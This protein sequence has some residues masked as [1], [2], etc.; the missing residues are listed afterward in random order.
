MDF[1][2]PE[3]RLTAGEKLQVFLLSLTIIPFILVIF[4]G[5]GSQ[6]PALVALVTGLA[7]VAAAYF[8]S[9]ATESLE[10]VVSQ[11]LALAVLALI[12]VLPEYSFEVVLVWGGHLE[13][14]AATMTGAN[15]LLLGLGW[16]AIFFL[17]Y[18]GS[19]RRHQALT[20]VE[21]DRHQ[22][23]EIVFLLLASLYSLVIVAK[24]SLTALDA[25]VLVAIYVAYVFAAIRLPRREENRER[26]A[27][28]A[29]KIAL[30][31]GPRKVA[32]V[33]TL[34][35]FGAFVIFFGAEPF[36]DSLL[37]VAV[38]L[39]LSEYLFVQ[40][41]APFLSEFPESLTAFIWAYSVAKAPMGLANLVSSKL[42]QWTLLMATIPLVYSLSVGHLATLKLNSLQVEE[43]MLTAAQTFFGIAALL[44]LRFGWRQATILFGLFLVQFVYPPTHVPVTIIFVVLAVIEVFVK[45]HN[46]VLFR[47]FSQAL[48]PLYS[49]PDQRKE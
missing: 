47:E 39:G 4:V 22:A 49:R 46:L 28:I 11:T 48:F 15:R 37:H 33:S 35:A 6:Q 27:G 3:S 43:I 34:L 19:R 23:V 17:A 45:R 38:S 24:A 13:L 29:A 41:V 21:L 20:A 5:W 18:W 31:R 40:W 10:T 32:T 16:P 12:Q 26:E 36:I 2:S 1:H 7:I 8:L 42:N 44:D 30:T 14:A 25:A 9:W